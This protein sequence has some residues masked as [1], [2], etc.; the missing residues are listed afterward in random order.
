MWL[1]TLT[2]KKLIISRVISEV[3]EVSRRTEKRQA[4]HH[5]SHKISFVLFALCL[6]HYFETPRPNCYAGLDNLKKNDYTNRPVICIFKTINYKTTVLPGGSL[7]P[8]AFPSV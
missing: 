5:T 8:L 3:H 6:F 4:K 2:T 1:I 7:A